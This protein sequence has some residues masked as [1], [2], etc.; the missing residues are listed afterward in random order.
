MTSILLKT[1]AMSL[2]NMCDT[3]AAG[4]HHVQPS[5]KSRVE[6][7]I[8]R[9]GPFHDFYMRVVRNSLKKRESF[10]LLCLLFF[11]GGGG[12]GGAVGVHCTFFVDDW[13]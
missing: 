3:Q 8:Y 7:Q 2:Y 1:A 9:S 11:L 4:S 6:Q 10:L 13:V 12:G 5:E